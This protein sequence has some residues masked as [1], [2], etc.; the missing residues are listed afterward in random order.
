MMSGSDKE[1][2]LLLAIS[3]KRT[4]RRWWMHEINEKRECLGEYHRLCVELQS[5]EDSSTFSVNSSAIPYCPPGKS[6]SKTHTSAARRYLDWSAASARHLFNGD[7]AILHNNSSNAFPPRVQITARRGSSRSV[8]Q[9]PKG[10][11]SGDMGG[12]SY[13]HILRV[14]QN[15]SLPCCTELWWSYR[16]VIRYVVIPDVFGL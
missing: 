1:E 11:T 2:L 9:N 16:L 10:L 12:Q 5:H 8:W 6:V 7:D 3:C 15:R 14:I 4:R 13:I